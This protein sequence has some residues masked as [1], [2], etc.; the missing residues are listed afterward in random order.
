[1]NT[2]LIQELTQKIL[3]RQSLCS[4]SQ[5]FA[6]LTWNKIGF[7]G[8]R[9]R[10]RITETTFTQDLVF[11][12]WLIARDNRLSVEIYESKNEKANGNDFEIF[13]ETDK[14]YLLLPTQSKLIKTNGSYASI[15]HQVRGYDQINLLID[16]AKRNNGIPLYLFYNYYFNPQFINWI[17]KEITFPVE[18]YGCSIASATNIKESFY[19][20]KIKK[21]GSKI[22]V[23]PHFESLHPLQALP[24]HFLIC[25]AEEK[26]MTSLIH[27]LHDGEYQEPFHYHSREELDDHT[28]WTNLAPPPAIGF[29]PGDDQKALFEKLRTVASPEFLPGYRIVISK[30]RRK[31][32]LM[33]YVS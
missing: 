22:W 28:G 12:F 26:D 18:C 13:V 21:D 6:A 25:S 2:E 4:W 8:N 11:N 30:E 15:R 31:S 33:R 10:L 9:K 20:K 7:T 1:M 14:G 32:S 17:E 27:Q 5:L 29:I 3:S 19:N 24:L 16:Y 23:I